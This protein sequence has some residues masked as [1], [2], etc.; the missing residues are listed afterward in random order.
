[1]S[2]SADTD[3]RSLLEKV[4]RLEL[5]NKR[6]KERS[7]QDDKVVTAQKTVKV[8]LPFSNIPHQAK[9]RI[10]QSQPF[11]LAGVD[12]VIY[13]EFGDQ[14]RAEQILIW[15]QLKSAKHCD[16][17]VIMKPMI[18]FQ[19]YGNSSVSGSNCFVDFLRLSEQSSRGFK[20]VLSERQSSYRNYG[21]KAAMTV[22]VKIIQQAVENLHA[23]DSNSNVTVMIENKKIQ[24]DA[25]Y[26]SKWS[27]FLQAY[28]AS[29][30]QEKSN[31]IYPIN[32]CSLAD[33]NEML[34]VI[35]PS[36]KPIDESNVETMIDIAD[37]FLM[38]M[39]TR[40]CEL[41]LSQTSSHGI[42]EIQMLAM[43]DRFNLVRTRTIV[44]ERLGSTT[45]LRSKVIQTEGYAN[46]SKE[47]K[48]SV[49]ARYVQLDVKERGQ[50]GVNEYR[51]FDDEHW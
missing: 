42:T 15:C 24:V 8:D 44:L 37:R 30:M 38:P 32:D 14:T 34:A 41:F 3:V 45:L 20:H 49:D 31:G 7:V 35:Y 29:N 33:F 25:P 39:L 5:E 21:N 27:D 4:Q 47:M 28:F 18:N 1:N 11:N 10:S 36:S 50:K 23:A 12:V 46:L 9:Q 13:V 48:R 51:E 26:V 16:V 40:K 2:D 22:S 6:L 43:A 17:A 19:N